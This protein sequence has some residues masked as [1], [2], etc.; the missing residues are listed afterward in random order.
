MVGKIVK[1]FHEFIQRYWKLAAALALIAVLLLGYALY[2]LFSHE[3]TD[4]AFIEGDVTV[5]SPKVPGHIERVYINDNQIVKAQDPLCDIDERDYQ[6]SFNL[7]QAELGAQ[8]A[9]AQ[10]AG[11]DIQRYQKLLASKDIP[12]QQYDKALLRWNTAK[13]QVN[14]AQARRA[15]ARLNLSYTKIVAPADGV[16]TRKNV[17]PGMFVEQGQALLAI[18]LPGRWVIANLKETQMT[19]VHPGLKVT[20][21][22]DAYP[23]VVFHGHLESIQQGTGARFSLLPAENATGNYIKVVQ[24]VPVKIVFDGPLDPQKPLELGMSV[25]PTIDLSS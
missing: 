22:V 18:V 13:A 12:Q 4:D 20:I 21:R 6:A 25:V 19:H 11:Q 24:R 8:E 1:Q 3:T 15:Q 17:E 9:E 14:A 2:Y 7:A 16:V 23:G 10:Q 5:I